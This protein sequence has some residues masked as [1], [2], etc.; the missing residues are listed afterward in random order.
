MAELGAQPAQR[1]RVAGVIGPEV[2]REPVQEHV[3]VAQSPAA[4]GEPAAFRHER[5]GIRQRQGAAEGLQ[6]GPDAAQLDAELVQG[7]DVG[8]VADVRQQ[9]LQAVRAG[10]EPR[11]DG[12]ALALEH[13]MQHGR[14]LVARGSRC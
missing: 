11:G 13:G 9:H 4:A 12:V 8:L 6:P 3:D 1:R 14:C 2:F 10:A 7:L 5:R